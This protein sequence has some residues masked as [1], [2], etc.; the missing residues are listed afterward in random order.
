MLGPNLGPKHSHVARIPSIKDP[1][2][3]RAAAGRWNFKK[4]VTDES[5]LGRINCCISGGIWGSG[6]LSLAIFVVKRGQFAI[7]AGRCTGSYPVTWM[8]KYL[9]GFLQPLFPSFAMISL[10]SLYAYRPLAHALASSTKFTTTCRKYLD[11]T[12]K[13]E[14]CRNQNFGK[15]VTRHAGCR[16]E[17]NTTVL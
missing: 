8:F 5:L 16:I 13:S 1:F 15:V 17:W 12:V 11:V 2:A 10:L 3:V 14:G 4:S 9:S 7:W 6:G